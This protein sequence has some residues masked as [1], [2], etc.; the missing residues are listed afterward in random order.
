M[1][2]NEQSREEMKKEFHD[3][4]VKV[5]R[6]LAELDELWMCVEDDDPEISKLQDKIFNIV[7]EHKPPLSVNSVSVIVKKVVPKLKDSD[8]AGSYNW[9]F[10]VYAEMGANKVRSEYDRIVSEFESIPS[11]IDNA[12]N[13]TIAFSS[14]YEDKYNGQALRDV[15]IVEFNDLEAEFN[16]Y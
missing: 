8:L 7:N 13:D 6:L 14:L 12:V 4:K 11:P 1:Y 2:T 9:E 16:K 3:W 5:G 10:K 15:T